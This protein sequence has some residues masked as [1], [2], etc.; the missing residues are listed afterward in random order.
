MWVDPTG[1]PTR[2]HP[3]TLTVDAGPD[4]LDS[5]RTIPIVF[6]LVD[7]LGRIFPL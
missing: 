7:E 1:L 2:A 4:I 5:P 3:A 6:T